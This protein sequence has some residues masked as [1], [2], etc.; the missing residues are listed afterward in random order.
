MG[1]I[2]RLPGQCHPFCHLDTLDM[3]RPKVRRIFSMTR[4]PSSPQISRFHSIQTCCSPS[5]TMQKITN[6]SKKMKAARLR[7]ISPEDTP[8]IHDLQ[9]LGNSQRAIGGVRHT[10]DDNVTPRNELFLR[11]EGRIFRELVGIQDRGAVEA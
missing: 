6:S 4:M 9:A 7:K 3:V 2:A 11:D 1:F 5:S 10:D 8:Q